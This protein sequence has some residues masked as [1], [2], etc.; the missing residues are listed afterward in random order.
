MIEV[1]SVEKEIK[2]IFED[3]NI[4][5]VK[6][7]TTVKEILDMLNNDQVIAL[8]INGKIVSSETELTTDSYV[9]YITIAS[10]IG[11]K[12]YM[13]G[14][15]Y[16]YLLAVKELY[17]DRAIVYIKHSLDKSLYTEIKMKRQ[18]DHTVVT[19]IKKIL[20]KIIKQQI[21]LLKL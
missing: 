3:S 17:E 15:T 2:L 7:G 10:R 4:M 8:R 12:I 21:Q 18:V 11:R 16:V 20:Q 1:D 5:N 6:S 13:K 19:Q 14:L 9:N